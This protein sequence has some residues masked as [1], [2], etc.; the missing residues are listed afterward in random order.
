MLGAAQCPHLP[1]A[2]VHQVA[3]FRRQDGFVPIH[4]V[5]LASGGDQQVAGMQVGVAQHE[6]RRRGEQGL[7][8]PAGAG[9]QIHDLGAASL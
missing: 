6:F 9:D 2:G 7:G 8:E 3:L 5:Q 1:A 4:Q